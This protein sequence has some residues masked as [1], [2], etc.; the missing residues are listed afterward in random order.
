MRRLLPL[1]LLLA[2]GCGRSTLDRYPKEPPAEVVASAIRGG[3]VDNEHPAV[4]LIYNHYEG[5]LCSGTL[6]DDMTVLTA[7][8]CVEDSRAVRYDIAGGTDPFSQAEWVVGAVEAAPH[9]LYSRTQIGIHDVGIIVLDEKP[10][11]SPI[12]WQKTLDDKAYE[13]GTDF[14]AVGY[15]VTSESTD[16]SGVKR[17]VT[18]SIEEV[19]SDA[20]AYGGPT[21]NICSGD[22]GGPDIVLVD[23]KEHVIGVHSYGD[24]GCDQFG[25]SM[26][27]DDNAEFIAKYV[28]QPE[29][30]GNA[31]EEAIGCSVSGAS[32]RSTLGL[33]ALLALAIRR[34]R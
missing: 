29:P 12:S 13:V 21:K 11:V 14:V 10:P 6:I 16:D 5:Y 32:G 22:S 20:Y 17:K 27:T 3:T 24:I 19:A 9:P 2:A 23:G 34:R 25:A 33:L 8:H 7:G 15:G 4:V 18:L 28:T 31:V 1:V 30:K 26:R